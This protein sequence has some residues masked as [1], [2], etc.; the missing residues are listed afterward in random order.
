MYLNT[1]IKFLFPYF[2]KTCFPGLLSRYRIDTHI[3]AHTHELSCLC[4]VG[5]RED[6]MRNGFACLSPYTILNPCG[7]SFYPYQLHRLIL[8]AEALE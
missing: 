2:L 6:G 8:Y 7:K 4:G 5:C 3:R 1:H